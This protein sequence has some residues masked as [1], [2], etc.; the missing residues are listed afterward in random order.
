MAIDGDQAR[1]E[2]FFGGKFFRRFDHRVMLG[3]RDENFISAAFFLRARRAEYG[4]IIRFRTARRE[5]HFA[6]LRADQPR[7]CA[8]RGIERSHR[9]SAEIMLRIRVAESFGKIRQHDLQHFAIERGGRRVIEINS[10][11]FFHTSLLL[12]VFTAE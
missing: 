1:F 2:I 8:A 10:F 5:K 6:V 7:D 11:L 3:G 12:P 4:E 9:F